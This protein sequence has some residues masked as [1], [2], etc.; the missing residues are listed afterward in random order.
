ME[1]RFVAQRDANRLEG[2]VGAQRLDRLLP[3]DRD[4]PPGD[5]QLDLA[6]HQQGRHQVAQRVR[7]PAEGRV[8][9]VIGQALAIHGPWSFE[10]VA[11]ADQR[12][13]VGLD[14]RGAATDL[15]QPKRSISEVMVR[16]L[17]WRRNFS[18]RPVSARTG[19][20]P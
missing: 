12:L 17:P 6:V 20:S 19:A 16:R 15:H 13:V 10:V 3:V 7:R 5:L 14:A 9:E 11:D 1:G 18:A 2:V 8:A 4:L